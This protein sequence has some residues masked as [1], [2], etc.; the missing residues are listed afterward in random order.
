MAKDYNFGSLNSSVFSFLSSLKICHFAT[1]SGI[2]TNAGSR[3][4]LAKLKSKDFTLAVANRIFIRKGF[5][6]KASFLKKVR[7]FFYSRVGETDFD[8]SANAAKE[9]NEWVEKRTMQKIKDL[10]KPE[11]LDAGTNLVLVNAIYFKADWAKKFDK[12]LT[13]KKRFYTTEVEGQPFVSM[14]VME[15][16]LKV[17]FHS[18]HS[19]SSFFP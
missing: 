7:K 18:L 5:S 14:M 13:K 10:V 8:K 16:F 1:L 17:T 3:C 4:I 11:S 15:N 12:S 2:V 6:P 19:E 9:I